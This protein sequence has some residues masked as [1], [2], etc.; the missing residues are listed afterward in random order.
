MPWDPF[1]PFLGV[2][3]PKMHM[4]V[5]YKTCI[6]MFIVSFLIAKTNKPRNNWNALDY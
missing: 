1:I 2:P 6:R 3:L 5:H 4:Y